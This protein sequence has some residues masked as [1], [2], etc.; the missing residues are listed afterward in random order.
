VKSAMAMLGL[1]EET[2]RLPMVPPSDSSRSK[3]EETLRE[4]GLTTTGA[5]TA[6][7]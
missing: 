6:S 1:L 5:A 4:L 3:I 2:Y 7:A